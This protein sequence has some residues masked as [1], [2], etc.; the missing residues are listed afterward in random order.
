MQPILI[1]SRLTIELEA[2]L[3]EVNGRSRRQTWTTARELFDV[4][5]QVEAA[6]RA[7]GVPHDPIGAVFVAGSGEVLPA[8]YRY[9]VKSTV[10]TIEC[11]A[12][13]WLLIGAERGMLKPYLPPTRQLYLPEIA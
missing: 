12:S 2:Q 4:V 3:R 6:M 10:V 9:S 11:T 5:R 13:G 8:E 1:H 7:Q